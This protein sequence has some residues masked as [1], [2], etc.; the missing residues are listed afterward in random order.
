MGLG[1]RLHD[2]VVKV[3]LGRVNEH[4]DA[5]GVGDLVLVLVVGAQL[6]QRARHTRLHLGVPVVMLR[7]LDQHLG[8]RVRVG[9]G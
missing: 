8:V 7:R 5:V 3:D 2:G 4:R 9:L 1:S 6:P